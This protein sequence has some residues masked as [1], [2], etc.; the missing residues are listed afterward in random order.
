MKVTKEIKHVTRENVLLAILFMLC[1]MFLF[2]SANTVVKYLGGVSISPVQ[3]VFFRNLL[4][5]LVLMAYFKLHHKQLPTFNLD[6]VKDFSLRGIF[7]TTG[8]SCLF[9]AY[10][11]GNLADVTAISFTSPLFVSIFAVFML[12]ERLTKAQLLGLCV[13]FLGALVVTQ[14]TGNIDLSPAVGALL[15]ALSGAYLMVTDRKLRHYY[16]SLEIVYFF[17]IM[18]SVLSVG[19]AL[20]AWQMPSNLEWLG[21]LIVAVLGGV[22]QLFI[23]LSYRRA[24]AKVVAQ[25]AYVSVVIAAG[26]N[27]GLFG[28]YPTVHLIIGSLLIAGGG[29]YVVYHEKKVQNI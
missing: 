2:T 14:P 6:V 9:Y 24:A 27:Y 12:K 20:Y 13:G 11:H 8:L 17:S 7:S 3:L 28:I 15:Y 23:A 16:T 10:M 5:A 22:A 26:Y 18:C 1:A 21:V 19:P 29:V 25:V 4:P